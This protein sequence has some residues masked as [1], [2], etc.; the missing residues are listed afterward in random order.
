VIASLCFNNVDATNGAADVA[1]ALDYQGG[2]S[3]CTT[4]ANSK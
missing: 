4:N 2:E 3:Y 1:A